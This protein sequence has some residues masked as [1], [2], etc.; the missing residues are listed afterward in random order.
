[1][2]HF[3]K[4]N[5]NGDLNLGLLGFATD[6]YALLGVESKKIHKRVA[7]VLK[8]GTH[9]SR[10]LRNDLIGIFSTGNS[11]G[12]VVPDIIE[13]EE[14]EQLR[15][16][17]ERIFNDDR[18]LVIRTMYALGNL[19]LMNDNGIIISPFIKKE[20]KTLEDFFGIKCEVS[21]IAK[22]NVVGSLAIV[23]NK[24]C[25]THPRTTDS[26]MKLLGKI[27]D[28]PIDIGTVSF[29][30]SFPGAGVIANSFG[31]VASESTS[32]IELGN[33]DKALGFV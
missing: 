11:T 12:I 20:R 17:S 30:S 27:L 28:I 13:D 10:F 15:K 5:F 26:E 14:L 25:L 32:G 2:S 1:M 31:F 16:V 7:E 6:S 33:I 18:V 24:G 8:V 9:H 21:T 4:M 3:A 19:I 22:L 29:G 23:T